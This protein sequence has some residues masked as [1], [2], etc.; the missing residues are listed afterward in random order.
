[1][2]LIPIRDKLHD[3]AI[4]ELVGYSVFPD[5]EKL[6]AAMESYESNDNILMGYSLDGEIIGV[7]GYRSLPDEGIY[8]RHLSVDPE[9]RGL[10]YGRGMILELIDLIKPK[11]I[12]LETDDDAVDFYRS[13]GFE[14]TSL[15][16]KY[17]HAER[18]ECVFETDF[19]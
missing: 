12:K 2:V 5:P 14:I 15:G 8:I 7:I 11:K 17:P 9:Y 1:M 18:Y 19:A 3:D 13:I 4:M 6:K 10:G 16:Q